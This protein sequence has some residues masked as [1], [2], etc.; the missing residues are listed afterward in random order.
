MA[1]SIL[2]PLRDKQGGI[3]KSVD[4]YRKNVAD[5]SNRITAAALMRSGKLNGIPRMKAGYPLLEVKFKVDANGILI[6]SATEKRSGKS[7]EIDVIPFHGMT[8]FEIDRIIEDS[9]ENAMDDFNNRQLIEFRQT[10]ERIFRG[11]EENWETAENILSDL[12]FKG[13]QEQ[14]EKVKISMEGNDSQVLKS[15]IDKLGDLTRS[16][17]DTTIGRAI[18]SELK[19]K[20]A[21]KSG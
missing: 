14:I 7:A 20:P 1:I 11:L 2:D 12:E 21:G 17:A 18:F 13:I 8:Q 4:W 15:Q 19:D 3:R 6:V 5:L 10:A 16:L 9:F